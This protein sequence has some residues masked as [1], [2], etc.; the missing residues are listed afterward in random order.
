[1]SSTAFTA[2]PIAG[3]SS[4]EPLAM[5]YTC[6]RRVLRRCAT[7]RRLESYLAGCGCDREAQVVARG[8]L[9]FFDNEVPQHYADE[10]EELFPALIES[11]AGSDAVRPSSIAR[12]MP[13]GAF[14]VGLWR[15]SP[16]AD[17][18]SCPPGRWKPSHG[19]G[20]TRSGLKRSSCWRWLH[21]C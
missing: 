14:C 6:H 7:L 5:L 2:I 8:L 20:M 12:S 13:N 1:M 4:Q 3:A 18:S 11:M 16:Q 21:A 10:E 15:R 17:R 9:R 19:T